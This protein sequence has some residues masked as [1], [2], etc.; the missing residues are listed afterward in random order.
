MRSRSLRLL[1]VLFLSVTA[2]CGGGGSSPKSEATE[3]ALEVAVERFGDA[4]LQGDSG[5]AYSF[6][7]QQCRDSVKKNEFG[8]LL[9]LA[10][11]FL[12]GMADVKI[13]DL[14]TT[15]VEIRDF[16]SARA[17]ARAEVQT[18]DG[19]VFSDAESE[20]WIEWIYE[21]GGWHTSDCADFSQ[22]SGD[23]DFDFEGGGDFDM[24]TGPPCSDLVDGQPVPPQFVSDASGEIDVSCDD[25]GM[26]Q[27]GIAWECYPSGRQYTYNDFGY[28]FLD[29]GIFRT[30]EVRGCSPPCSDLVDGQS[31]P[32]VFDD[33]SEIGFTLTCEREDGDVQFSYDWDC[34]SSDRRYMRNDDGYAFIDERVYRSGSPDNC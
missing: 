7:T 9:K 15:N 10:V 4:I 33:D 6:F 23:I 17:E 34:Y 25:D 26:Y 16:T 5:T 21:D 11:S 8:M 24:F 29:E 3:G 30:G 27:F 28:A 18:K 20:G 31:V 12:E 1:S 32:S 22:S 14:R 19:E 2:A 13:S